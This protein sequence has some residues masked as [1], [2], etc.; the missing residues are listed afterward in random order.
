[1]YLVAFPMNGR[2]EYMLSPRPI[3]EQT[4]WMK[5]PKDIQD[6]LNGREVIVKTISIGLPQELGDVMG[7]SR[8]VLML[9]PD[10]IPK[11]K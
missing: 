11:E 2:I 5:K 7:F 6:P 4:L 9:L 3:T 1:M 8:Q 10:I